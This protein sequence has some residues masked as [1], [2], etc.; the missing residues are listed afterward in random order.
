[1]NTTER[2]DFMTVL[3]LTH[4]LGI[5]PSAHPEAT[6]RVTIHPLYP[7]C[8]EA[9]LGYVRSSPALL[10]PICVLVWQDPAPSTI[11]FTKAT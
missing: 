3:I 11:L 10:F 7:A 8:M 5:V 4:W 1:M 9:G 6:L 2:T